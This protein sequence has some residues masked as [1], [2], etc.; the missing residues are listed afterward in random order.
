M[1]RVKELPGTS[2]TTFKADCTQFLRQ[3]THHFQFCT[4]IIYHNNTSSA[5]LRGENESNLQ[6]RDESVWAERED[7]LCKSYPRLPGMLT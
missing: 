1:A 3:S 5:R 4:S 7:L 2:S 6:Y